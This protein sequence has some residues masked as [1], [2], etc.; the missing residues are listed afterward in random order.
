MPTPWV[1]LKAGGM[2]STLLLLPALQK[3]QW[4]SLVFLYLVVHNLAQLLMHVVI[5]SS[6][7]FLC[8]LLLEETFVQEQALQ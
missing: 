4:I 6:L 7:Y 3:W 8:I 5:F 1:M 2:G